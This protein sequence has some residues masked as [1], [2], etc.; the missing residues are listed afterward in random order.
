MTPGAHVESFPPGAH[1]RN[2]RTFDGKGSVMA[3]TRNPRRFYI[4]HGDDQPIVRAVP[5]RRIELA[6]PASP[7]GESVATHQVASPDAI[8]S[9][10][11]SFRARAKKAP[12][13]VSRLMQAAR[14]RSHASRF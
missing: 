6:P 7:A 5:V 11:R 8:E 3:Q 12:R 10:P 9:M 14:K 2:V 4:D 13:S 1:E